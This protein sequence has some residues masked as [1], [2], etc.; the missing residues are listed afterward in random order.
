VGLTTSE[1][2]ADGV[3]QASSM[4]CCRTSTGIDGSGC[5]GVP[6]ESM[7]LGASIGPLQHS[8]TVETY[9]PDP[10]MQNHV[11]RGSTEKSL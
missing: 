1:G 4:S 3:A 9:L 10:T 5:G 7:N 2:S 8:G 6:N 11:L